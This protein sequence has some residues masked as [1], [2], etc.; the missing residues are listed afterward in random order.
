M[1]KNQ[2]AQGL[3]MNV[4]IIATISLLVLAILIFILTTNSGTFIKGTSCEGLKGACV[5]EDSICSENYESAVY[6]CKKDDS[7]N[8]QRCCMPLPGTIDS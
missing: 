4:I 1:L 5:S 8:K 3:S 7:G 2:K 6:R